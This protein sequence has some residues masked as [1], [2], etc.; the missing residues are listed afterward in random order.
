M[1]SNDQRVLKSTNAV[2]LKADLKL[3]ICCANELGDDV[4]THLPSWRGVSVL[5][6]CVQFH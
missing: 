5:V 6:V 3:I 4:H 2:V 1:L